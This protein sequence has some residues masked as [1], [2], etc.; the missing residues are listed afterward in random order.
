MASN[1]FSGIF[2]W[3]SFYTKTHGTMISLWKLREK[4]NVAQMP[5]VKNTPVIYLCHTQGS[6]C[7]FS[8]SHTYTQ[9]WAQLQ[10][11]T[12]ALTLSNLW[13]EVVQDEDVSFDS[14]AM[15]NTSRLVQK[16]LEN[17]KNHK[18]KKIYILDSFCLFCRL[19]WSIKL[20]HW[21]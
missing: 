21:V 13:I 19:H 15:S 11:P 3:F 2:A 14:L 6:F 9:W 12:T 5:F 17:E 1:Q 8:Y 10:T 7:G 4:K 20:I 16:H 18:E